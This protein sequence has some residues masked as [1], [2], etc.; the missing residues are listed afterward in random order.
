ML[1][2]PEDFKRHVHDVMTWALGEKKGRCCGV[3][4]RY[5]GAH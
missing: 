2:M 1:A 3:L 5:H 4:V